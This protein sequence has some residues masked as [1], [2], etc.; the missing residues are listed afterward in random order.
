[1]PLRLLMTLCVSPSTETLVK[2]YGC[3]LTLTSDDN[4]YD[5]QTPTSTTVGL[6]ITEG[7]FY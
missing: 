7:V 2:E 3:L 5:I 1:M 6:Y 4:V